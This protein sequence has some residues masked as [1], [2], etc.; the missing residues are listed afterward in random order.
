MLSTIDIKQSRLLTPKCTKLYHEA[1]MLK[2]QLRR[3]K[4]RHQTFSE[5]LKAAEKI[6]EC[7]LDTNVLNT[8]TPAAAIFTKLQVRE[9]RNAPKGRRFTLQEKLLSLALYKQST[10]SYRV[11]S[12]WFTLPSRKT[13]SNLL[14]KIPIS[15]GLDKTFL[16]VLCANVQKLKEKD[17]FCALL[18]DEVSLDVQLHFDNSAGEIIGF[19]D[20]GLGRTQNFA[21][22]ALVFMVKGITKKYKQP[23]SYT[24]CK[25]STKKHDLANQIRTLIRGITST[26]LK[27]I[28]TISDQGTTNCAAINLLKTDTREFYLRNNQRYDIDRFYEIN[29]D[30]T[31]IKVIH[32]YDPPHLLKGKLT[33]IM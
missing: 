29:C 9:T 26:G 6:S 27:V 12:K 18:F 22:H 4:I 23:I 5:R 8:M 17:K 11:I 33:N 24:F 1:I 25:S 2:K 7:F 3:Q 31:R 21:D 10:K 32:L 30:G 13:L 16:K 19:E 20:N 28:A 14:S 15:T